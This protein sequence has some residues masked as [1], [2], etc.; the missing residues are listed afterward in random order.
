[1]DFMAVPFGRPT[2]IHLRKRGSALQADQNRQGA[3][4]FAEFSS[5]ATGSR[6]ARRTLFAP[7]H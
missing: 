1:V 5:P 3:R 4:A 2:I 7:P 6:Q